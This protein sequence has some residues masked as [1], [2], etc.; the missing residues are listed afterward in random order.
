VSWHD[1]ERAA[2]DIA[3]PGRARLRDA[4]VVMLGTL[5][6]GGA[7]R[8]SPIEPYFAGGELLFGAMTWSAKARDLGRDP[9]CTV[10]SAVSAPDAAEP[11]LK[12]HGRA[13]EAA[14]AQRDAC[15]DAWWTRRPRA[16]AWVF[17]LALDAAVWVEW[18]LER[19][20]M[21]VRR[22]SRARGYDERSR[23]YP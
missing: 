5:R 17:T 6:A 3:R 15:A 18:D 22:W 4:R 2:P 21:R 23:A 19:G 10:H 13:V 1:L 11:E 12:L 16:A 9:R 8:I 7:P 14:P 20:E